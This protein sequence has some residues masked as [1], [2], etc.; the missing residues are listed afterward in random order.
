MPRKSKVETSPHHEEIHNLLLQGKSSRWISKYLEEEYDEVI[1]YNAIYSYQKKNI[2]LE[3]RTIEEVNR[4]KSNRKKTEA[5]VKEK[6]D[7]QEKIEANDNYVI[8]QGADNLEG[9]LNVASNF[10]EDYEALKKAS[11]D[12]L[13]PVTEKDVANMSYKANKLYLDFIKSN[14]MKITHDGEINHTGSITQE[15][16]LEDKKYLEKLLN[17]TER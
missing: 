11:L 7:L 3:D 15:L 16:S 6:A 5:A 2:N 17:I 4:R 14:D 12:E 13:N 8:Q 9:I 1:G 10:P